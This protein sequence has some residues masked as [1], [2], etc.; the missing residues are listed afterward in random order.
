MRWPVRLTGRIR[1]ALIVTLR[2][3][4]VRHRV[5]IGNIARA[6][7]NGDDD[8]ADCDGEHRYP[9]GQRRCERKDVHAEDRFGGIGAIR[10]R[11][12]PHEYRE[13]Q[14]NQRSDQEGPG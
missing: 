7:H 8:A 10:R 11:E 9:E 1:F 4:G 13:A 2:M 3:T 14:R 5:G 12:Y 6:L